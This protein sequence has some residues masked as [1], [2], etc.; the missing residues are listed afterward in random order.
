LDEVLAVGDALFKAKCERK[1]AEL[2]R[3]GTAFVLVN[4]YAQ[5][6]LNI[7]N[8]GLY[9]NKGNVVAFGDARSGACVR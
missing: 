7:C 8:S 6:I 3:N 2:L 4:H 9:L 1:L 5:S